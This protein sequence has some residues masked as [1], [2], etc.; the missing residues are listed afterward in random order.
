[1][2]RL[3]QVGSVSNAMRG[4]RLLEKHGIRVYVRRGTDGSGKEGCG[5]GLLVS[6]DT[7]D[8][9]S[10]LTKNGITILSVKGRDGV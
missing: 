2:Q 5:Y 9:A 3:Y 8:V 4:K 7:P 10:L 1:M 6:A